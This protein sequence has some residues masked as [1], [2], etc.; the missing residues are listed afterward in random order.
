MKK[1]LLGLVIAVMMTGSGYTQSTY[2]ERNWQA[3]APLWP[4]PEP[5]IRMCSLIHQKITTSLRNLY[6][7]DMSNLPI[8]GDKLDDA[9]IYATVYN[10]VCK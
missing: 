9:Y 7:D 5:K 10:A 1:V 2:E 8:S 3:E 6:L 4:Y